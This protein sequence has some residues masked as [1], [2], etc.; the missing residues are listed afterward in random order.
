[1]KLAYFKNIFLARPRIPLG[2][3]T[4]CYDIIKIYQAAGINIK[5]VCSRVFMCVCI[6]VC[7]CG[8]R[9]HPQWTS[10]SNLLV[11]SGYFPLAYMYTCIHMYTSN[12]TYLNL[13]NII[14]H[15]TIDVNLQCR[16][17]PPLPSPKTTL[18]SIPHYY[19]RLL[20]S[21]FN[22]HIHIQRNLLGI[23]KLKQCY[24]V[25]SVASIQSLFHEF[26]SQYRLCSCR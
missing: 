5:L 9:L 18:V 14:Y 2:S 3:G 8:L 1:M 22:I 12:C 10:W 15:K 13:P 23:M 16:V 11:P 19:K 7:A 24:S 6:R 21:I 25:H 4:T 17:R 26:V 20:I